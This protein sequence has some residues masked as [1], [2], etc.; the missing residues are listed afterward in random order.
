MHS[1]PRCRRTR[2]RPSD[3]I[4]SVFICLTDA[5]P[6]CLLN[7]KT[8]LPDHF[9]AYIISYY[10]NT[11]CCQFWTPFWTHTDDILLSWDVVFVLPVPD[12]CKFVGEEKICFPHIP[13]HY[14][15]TESLQKPAPYEGVNRERVGS[16]L[17]ICAIITD[18]SNILK[19][20]TKTE[21]KMSEML[22][23]SSFFSAKQSVLEEN[24]VCTEPYVRGHCRLLDANV[25]GK[26]VAFVPLGYCQWLTL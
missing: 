2:L 11:V 10:W 6:T 15:F 24:D 13:S 18:F 12:F 1:A 25:I 17:C 8:S 4:S 3:S 19:I 20:F 23:L 16:K 9:N 14:F 7:N 22:F 26:H 21:Y 5:I